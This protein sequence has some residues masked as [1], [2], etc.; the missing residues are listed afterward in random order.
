MLDLDDF[1]KRIGKTV[2]RTIKDFIPS[3]S[4]KEITETMVNEVIDAT[5]RENTRNGKVSKL[6]LNLPNP[7][8]ADYV[9]HHKQEIYLKSKR[10]GS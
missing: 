4:D 2:R 3:L 8:I 5:T 10:N 9:C 1:K 6:F 7:L